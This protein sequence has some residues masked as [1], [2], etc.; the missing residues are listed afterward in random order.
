LSFRRQESLYPVELSSENRQEAAKVLRCDVE[1][2]QIELAD[3]PDGSFEILGQLV[4][5]HDSFLQR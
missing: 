1:L 5:P 4:F 2:A 3:S